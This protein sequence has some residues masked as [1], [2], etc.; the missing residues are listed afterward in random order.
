M[1]K[2]PFAVPVFALLAAGSAHAQSS[3]TLYGLIDAGF[4]YTNNVSSTSGKGALLQATSGNIGG[5]RFGLRGGEDLGSGMKALFVLENGYNVQNGNLKQ[6]GRFFG[7][8]AFLGLSSEQFGTLTLGRQYD[9]VADFLQPLSGAAGSFGDTGFAHPFD[10]DN[11]DN[12]LRVN[13]VAKYTSNT[14]AGLRFGGS[15]AF[16]NS[17]NF[18]ADR[19]YSFGASYNTGSLSIAAAYMQINGSTGT[20]SSSAGAIDINESGANGKAG[21]QLGAGAQRMFGGGLNYSLGPATLGF[22]YTHSLFENSTSFGSNGGNV[23]FDNYEVN[24]KYFLTPVCTLGLAYTYTNA[25]V[26]GTTTYGASPK[27]NAVDFQA[28]YFL[29]RRTDVY[30]EALYQHATGKNYV[31][32][33]NNSGGASSTPNQVVD[34]IGMR[35]RF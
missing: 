17:T 15:Y 23:S 5:S 6:D 24:G 28:V 18:A 11:L 9:S 10:N 7:R 26:H 2:I 29:S 32:F 3:V 25:S 14:I 20:T 35:T 21:F 4:M 19:L 13:N 12:S 34:M 31:A 30:F 16:S 1:K 33:I 22:V 8:Q 27:W